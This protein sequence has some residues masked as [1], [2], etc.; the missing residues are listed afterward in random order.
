MA[1]A[2]RSKLGRV[3]NCSL[4]SSGLLKSKNINYLYF[5]ALDKSMASTI[6]IGSSEFMAN[7]VAKKSSSLEFDDISSSE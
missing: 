5:G 1:G 6:C 2:P 4:I 3:D 7:W